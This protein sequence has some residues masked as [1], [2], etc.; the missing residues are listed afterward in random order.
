MASGARRY[1]WFALGD[2]NGFFGLMFD[3]ITVLSFLAGALVFAFGFP[4]DIVYTR[5]FPGTAFGVLFGDLVYSWMA[6]RL[7]RRTGNQRV[8]A[9]PLGLD[10]RPPSAWRLWFWGRHSPLSRPPA[11]KCGRPP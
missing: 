6:F 1:Q 7:S 5:M 3:N 8:T 2:I 9:M 10:T 11:W 4:A